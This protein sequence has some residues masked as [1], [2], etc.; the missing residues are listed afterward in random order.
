VNAKSTNPIS[1]QSTSCIFTFKI[2]V[3][4]NDNYTLWPTG[5][6]PSKEYYSNYPGDFFIPLNMYV[7]GPNI[8]W[9]IQEQSVIG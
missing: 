2:V 6:T 9:G 8:T 1:K 7:L 4:K 3:V 5:L